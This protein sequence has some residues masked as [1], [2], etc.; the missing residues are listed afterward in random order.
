MGRF[1]EDEQQNERFDVDNDFEGGEWIGGEFFHR[2]DRV[3]A[4]SDL[5]IAYRRWTTHGV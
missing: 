2:C 4:N 1:D 3:D 5:R